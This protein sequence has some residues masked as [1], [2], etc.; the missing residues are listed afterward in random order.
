MDQG[1]TLAPHRLASSERRAADQI[2]K[3]LRTKGIRLAAVDL[4]EG[5]VTDTN[6][7]SPGLLALMEGVLSENLSKP[8]IQALARVRPKN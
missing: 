8:V 2:G 7:T 1:G 3:V 6:F 5:K 4:I